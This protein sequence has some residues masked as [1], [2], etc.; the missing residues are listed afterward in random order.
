MRDATEDEPNWGRR[1]VLFFDVTPVVDGGRFAAKC[2]SGD[3]VDVQVDVV[4]DGHDKL[5]GAVLYRVEG[6]E[7]W[8]H[9]PLV[10]LVNDRWRGQFEVD[11][12]GYWEFAVQAWVEEYATWLW[13]I[14]RK[15]QAGQEAKLEFLEGAKLVRAAAQRAD[16]E[17]DESQLRAAA[18]RF[19]SEDEPGAKLALALG[20][21]LRELMARHGDRSLA[22]QT[23]TYPLQVDP[24]LARF[25]AWYEVFPRSLGADG[26]H[27][28]FADVERLLPYVKEMG[29]NVLYLPPAHPI[30]K[31]HRKG[32]NNSPTAEPND[33]GSPWAIGAAEGGHTAIHPQLGSV[34]DFE[35]LVQTARGQ[36]IEL[37]IDIAFQASPDHPYVKQH[38]EWFIQRADG[39]IQYAENPPKKYQ[40]VYPFDLA[41][42]AWESLYQE[43]LDV[44]LT[45]LKRGVRVFRVDNPHTKPIRFWQWCFHQIKREYPDAIFLAEAFTRPKLMYA[46][47][48][49]GFTQSYTYFTWRTA[50]WELEQYLSELCH[51][52]ARHFFRPNF[53]PNTPDILPEHLQHGGRPTFISRFVLAAT[54]SSNYGIYGPSFELMEHVARPGS[55]E[56][57]NNEKFQ[58]R[59]WNFDAP[60][61]LKPLITLV[62]QIRAD[63]PALHDNTSL[64]F[65]RSDNELVIAYSKVS[66]DGDN[67]L[68]IV[69]NLDAW[70]RHSAW[71]DLD[72]AALGMPEDAVFQAHDLLGN[73]Y[74]QWAGR[75]AYVELDPEAMPCHIFKLRRR[76]RTEFGFEYFA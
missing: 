7:Q 11:Q 33:V 70:N 48:K 31:T 5:A 15:V 58:L 68:L 43:L 2:V 27:G 36:G 21:L 39:S 42:A 18:E 45:W 37:A 66:K 38:P 65:H 62:N 32:P 55:E 14:Q 10:P 1:R 54:M 64:R 44:F 17:Q 25:S 26:Q 69:V 23:R 41:G 34:A 50:R 56:Y 35:K 75:R 49:V 4:C 74:Y 60:Q 22:S 8:Q 72:L 12:P 13:G 57:I 3:L 47:A 61:S 46:L 9:V 28:T 51:T 30:G 19:E 53:W 76:Q 71:L 63:N 29:F 67:V 20:P 40:D 73:A 24:P 16:A 59:S 6:N 52:E